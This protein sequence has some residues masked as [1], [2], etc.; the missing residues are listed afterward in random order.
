MCIIILVKIHASLTLA[1]MNHYDG[2]VV[3][4]IKSVKVGSL[5]TTLTRYFSKQ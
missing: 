5:R 2:M 3:E 4:K 1:S